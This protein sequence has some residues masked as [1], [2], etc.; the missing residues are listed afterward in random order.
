MALVLAKPTD[1]SDEFTIDYWKIGKSIIDWHNQKVILEVWGWVNKD[2]RIANRSIFGC[3]KYDSGGEDF[4]I[5]VES[6]DDVQTQL[7]NWL[8]SKPEWSGAQDDTDIISK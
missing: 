8:K 7:Y 1:K 2:D 6:V 3:K 5:D 4:P